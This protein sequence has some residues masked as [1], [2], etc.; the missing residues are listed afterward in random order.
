MRLV[1]LLIQ[2]DLDS[3]KVQ[4][5]GPIADMR[6]MHWLLGEARRCVEREAT[7]R[8]AA[9]GNGKPSLIV[10]PEVRLG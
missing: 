9:G 7:N 1:K 3:G 6:V 8:E 2:G 10:V 5:A 4:I